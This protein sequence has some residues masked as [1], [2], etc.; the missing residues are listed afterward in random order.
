MSLQEELAK[1]ETF[2]QSTWD[3]RI[4]DICTF[5]PSVADLNYYSKVLKYYEAEIKRVKT[6]INQEPQ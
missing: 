5:E 6:I 1:Y 4:Q 3:A 2:Y